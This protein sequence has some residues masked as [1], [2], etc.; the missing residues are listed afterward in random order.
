MCVCVCERTLGVKLG[1]VLG[2]SLEADSFPQQLYELLQ[3]R[4]RRLIVVHLFLTALPRPAVHHPHLHL[5]T[6]LER[7]MG[8]WGERE[9]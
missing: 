1:A 3:G 8:G 9:I 2:E 7:R 5:E 6:Q 4:A